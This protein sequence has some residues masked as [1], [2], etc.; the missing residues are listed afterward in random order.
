MRILFSSIHNYLDL[1]S[2][3]AVTTR[4]ELLELVR[5]GHQARTLC[6]ALFDGV[7][8]GEEELGKTLGR[9][10][11]P[12]QR[13]L[14]TVEVGG[15]RL[16]F[17]L[18]RF[19]DSGIDSTVFIPLDESG[20]ETNWRVEAEK[21]F[22]AALEEE[23]SEFSPEI[24]ASYGGQR[25]VVASALKAKRRGIKSVFMLHNLS[26][27][28]PKLFENFDMVVVPSEYVRRRYREML[29]F[30]ARVLAP[31][32]AP[33][34]VVATERI[35]RFLTFVTPTVEKGLYFF[36]GIARE[37]GAKRPDIPILLVEG[38]GK[39]QRLAA[40][41]E[42]RELT[43]LHVL[44]R[45]ES[46]ALFFRETRLLLVPSLCEETFGRVVVEAGLNG[47][48]ALCSDRGAIPEVVGDENLILSIP[49][50]F[51]P[52]TR[53]V[54]T[55]EEVENWLTAIIALWD[56]SE[57]LAFLGAQLRKH[58]SRYEK[59]VVASRL[60]TILKELL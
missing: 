11:I 2:G 30:D 60:E 8:V 42:A 28:D 48:P 17:K 58:V 56:D 32:I 33:E 47:I 25:T 50:R 55:S 5:R 51:T 43:N 49:P 27:R 6:G 14:T 52:A 35:P 15:V 44:E 13:N 18:Y 19:N 41:P 20:R 54:P 38:R 45:V 4:E 39:I 26:Y 59:D 1:G 57:R 21:T 3:A 46:P 36:I 10:G 37:L 7:R 12:A 34:K 40:I 16:T 9:L 22:L 23:F 24:F 29:G 53:E 31:L